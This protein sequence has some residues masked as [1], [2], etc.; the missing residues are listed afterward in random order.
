MLK[1]FLSAVVFFG[2][3][4]SFALDNNTVNA[5]SRYICGPISAARPGIT[6]EIL[7]QAG[8]VFYVNYGYQDVPGS[9]YPPPVYKLDPPSG[10]IV[11]KS[12][13]DSAD[14]LRL[15]SENGKDLMLIMRDKDKPSYF[16]S[17]FI[18]KSFY[19]GVICWVP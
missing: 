17:S 19:Y 11:G 12:V 15:V 5:K 18:F 16:Q 4:S 2:A 13:E 1:R 3:S 8:N 14:I 7:Q 9:P 10:S 6:V